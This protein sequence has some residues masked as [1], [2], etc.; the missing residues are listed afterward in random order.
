MG[1]LDVSP[2]R[3]PLR[4]RLSLFDTR[5]QDS[6]RSF[7]IPIFLLAMNMYN[8]LHQTQRQQVSDGVYFECIETTIEL[9]DMAR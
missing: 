7:H 4:L 1:L 5:R 3:S 9:S 6:D 8:L 2:E